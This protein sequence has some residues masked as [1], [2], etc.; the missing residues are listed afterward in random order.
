MPVPTIP[1]AISASAIQT[2]FGGANPIAISEYYAGGTYVPSGTANATSVAIPTTGQIAFSNFSGATSLLVLVRAM[3]VDTSTFLST[4]NAYMRFNY[5]ASGAASCVG[6]QTSNIGS[7]NYV[8]TGGSSAY[9]IRFQRVTGTVLSGVSNNVWL[10]LN[11]NRTGYIT[12]GVG[13]LILNTS[14]VSI[15]YNANSTII[16]SNI[17]AWQAWSESTE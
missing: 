9:D 2:E 5:A 6:G 16:D 3:S 8:S 12:A 17:C 14:N 7:Y 10:R 4:A 1:S 11:T 15:K 13:Q